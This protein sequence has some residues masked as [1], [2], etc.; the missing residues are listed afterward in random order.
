MAIPHGEVRIV[1]SRHYNISFFGIERLHPFD[2][3]DLDAHQ[4]NGVCHQFASDNRVF[5]Y[6]QYNRDIYPG[7]DYEAKERID[8]NHP[9]P[10]H[11]SSGMYLARLRESLPPFLGS[12]AKTPLRLAIY[13]AGTDP[14]IEDR[15]GGLQL[16]ADD[17]LQRDRF[18]F[19][20]FRQRGLPFVMLLSGG[21]SRQSHRLVAKSVAAL[22]HE[23]E[24]NN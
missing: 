14:F 5:I 20:Q 17:I 7:Y 2:S 4:G 24:S 13:N 15:L 16:S 21:Y 11:C 8:A 23:T 18:V 22:L 3:R 19:Q 1:Y 10:H 9:L 6:D 12:L